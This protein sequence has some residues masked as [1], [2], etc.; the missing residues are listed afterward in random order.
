MLEDSLKSSKKRAQKG[1]CGKIKV[2]V[3]SVQD[4]DPDNPYVWGLLD[5]HPDL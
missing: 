4:P 5:P 1:F 2:P 3:G